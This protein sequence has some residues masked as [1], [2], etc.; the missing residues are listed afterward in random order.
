MSNI[1]KNEL[2][3][4]IEV[5]NEDKETVTIEI[6]TA[7]M[8][9][10]NAITA[11]SLKFNDLSTTELDP[12]LSTEDIIKAVRVQAEKTKELNELTDL[13]FGEDL[14]KIVFKGSSSLVVYKNF[15]EFFDLE[16]VKVGKK[17]DEYVS[18]VR[19]KMLLN[20]KK[21]KGVF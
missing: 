10:M 18:K 11:V 6:D 5:S 20:D 13:A 17:N 9:Q 4:K 12:N 16:M 1:I 21:E 2:I 19:K 7:D 15:L 3:Y 8:I 14:R